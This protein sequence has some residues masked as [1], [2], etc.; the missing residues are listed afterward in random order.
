MSQM[1]WVDYIILAIF[2]FSILGG[3]G[4]GFVREMISLITLIAAFVI[5]IMFSNKLALAFTS[6]PSVQSV[7]TQT[8]ST[9]G[10]S[11]AQPVSYLA[12]GISFGV[13]FAGTV[14][15][16]AL[17]GYFINM[18]FQVGILG[19]GNRLL[20]AVFGLVRGFII[21]LVLIFVVQATPLGSQ[22]W[23]Q[24]SQFVAA[25]QPAVEWLGSVVSPT[26]ATLKS[27]VGD[28]IKDVGSQLQDIT[29]SIPSFNQ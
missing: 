1:N 27:K 26:L 23:W 24:Q 6:S 15:A 4:R 29:N 12:L 18:A 19:L 8:T 2:F 5:A 22:P 14:L 16:G 3:L 28:T 11:T 7:V 25:Y 13:L 10:M 9:I 20:G 21:N 17:I